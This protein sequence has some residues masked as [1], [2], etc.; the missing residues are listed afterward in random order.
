MNHKTILIISVVL[1][2]CFCSSCTA[3]FP[4]KAMPPAPTSAPGMEATRLPVIERST[5]IAQSPAAGI[6]PVMEGEIVTMNINPDVPD[7]RCMVV[8]SEQR[9]QVVNG[10][11]E[12]LTVSLGQAGAEIQPGDSYTFTDPFGDLLLP[13]VHA[14]LVLPCCGGEIVLEALE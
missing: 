9:L 11:E 14:L 4:S 2:F 12:A 8:R 13:G 10:R 5:P 7:P 6:C 1:A 3:V